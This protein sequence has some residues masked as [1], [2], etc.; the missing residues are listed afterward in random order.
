[1]GVSTNDYDLY[2]LDAT[3]ANV[4]SSS[5]TVQNGSQDPFEIVPPPNV[6]ERVVVVKASG[7]PRFLHI[8]TIRG[9][10]AIGTDGNITGHPCAVNAFATAAVDVHT[11]YPNPFTGGAANPVEYFSTDGPRRVFYNADGTAITPG[12]FSSTG[13]FV[14]Q[15]PDIA[16]ADGVST[17]LP[18][19]SGLNPFYGT[20]AAA[21]HAGAIAALLKSYNPNLTTRQIRGVLTGTALDIEAPGFDFNSGSGIVM[22]LQAIQGAPLPLPVPDLVLTTNYIFGGNGNGV[23]D[24]NECNN[25]IL[26]LDNLG[27]GDATGVRATLSTVTPNVTVAQPSSLYPNIPIGASATNLTPFQVSTAPSFICG[28]PIDFVLVVKSDQNTTTNSFTI[29]GTPG[30][31]LRLDNSVPAFIPDVGITNSIIVVSNVISAISK[32]TVSLYI[33][34]TYDSDLLLQLVSPDGTTNTLSANHGASGHNYGLA[35]SPDS[36]RTTFDDAALIPVSLGAP[37]F[38]GSFIP[39]QPLS[40]FAGKSGTNVNGAWTLLVA[41]QV[42]QDFGTLNCWSLMITPAACADGGGECPGADMAIGMIAQPEPVLLGNNLTYTLSVTNNGPSTA[43]TVS[44]AQSLPSTVVFISAS[45]SQGSCSEVG[46]VVSCNLGQMASHGRATITVVVQPTTLGVLS[47]TATVSSEQTDFDPS[48]NSATAISHVNAPTADLALGLSGAPAATVVGGSLTYS[49]AVTNLGPSIATGVTVTNVLPVGVNILSA[50]SSQGSVAISGN[51]VVCSFGTLAL[52]ARATTTI[53]VLPTAVGTFVA[54]STVYGNQPDP[55]A[56]NNSASVSTLVG[57]SADVAVSI[58]DVPDPVV[59]FS[60]LTYRI[61]VTNAGPSPATSVSLNGSLPASVVVTSNYISQGSLSIA[62]TALSANVGSLLNGATATIVLV[63]T[64]TLNGTIQASVSVSATESDP[65]TAN[66]SASASTFVSAPFVLIAPS[67]ASLVAESF[68]PPDGA[69]DIGETVTVSL[70]LINLGNVR[71]TNLVATL[72]ATNGVTPVGVSTISY[73]LLAPSGFEIGRSFSFTANGTNGGTIAP[74]LHLQD[75]GGYSTNVS[76]TF[77]LPALASFANTNSITIPDPAAPNPPYLWESG[78]AKPYPSTINVSGLTGSISKVTA[79]LSNLT[80]TYVQDVNVL[81]VGPG[82]SESLLMSHVGGTLGVDQV[83]LTF[84]DSADFLP[85]DSDIFSDSYHPT[86]NSPSVVFPAAAPAGPYPAA[87]STFIGVNPNGAWSLYVYDDGEGD[88]GQ[89]ANGWSLAFA[90]VTPINQVADLGVSITASPSSVRVSDYLTYTFT[91][92]NAGPGIANGIAFTNVLPATAA[93]VTNYVS[94]GSLSM[95]GT[96]LVA[97]LGALNPGAAATVTVVVQPTAAG[98]LS[99]T[100]SVSTLSTDLYTANNTATLSVPIGFLPADVALNLSASPSS[101]VLGSNFVFTLTVTNV[102]PG[103]A[104]SVMVTNPLPLGAAFVTNAFQAGTNLVCNLG[105]IPAGATAST[106]LV[107]RATSLGTLTNSATV[108]LGNGQLDPN[109]ANNSASATAQVLLPFINIVPAG[110]AITSE[111]FSPPNGIVDPGETVTVQFSLKNLGSIANSSLTATLLPTGGVTLPSGNQNYG[112]LLPNGPSVAQPFSFIASPA[113]GG[114]LIA[115]L[116]LQDSSGWATNV[117]FLLASGNRFANTNPITIPDHGVAS[118]FPSTIS[119]SGLTGIVTKV[120]V[121]LSNFTHAFPS[122]VNVLLVTTNFNVLLMSHAGGA[123][124]L[125]NPTTITFD[126]NS[127]NPALPVAA[128]ITNGTYRPS[129]YGLT[130]AFRSP[131]APKAPFGSALAAAIGTNPNGEWDLYVLDDSVGDAGAIAG[132]WSLNITTI[133]NINPLADLAVGISPAATALFPRSSAPY[134]ITVTNLGPDSA[135]GVVLTDPFPAGFTVGSA[136]TTQ[137]TV[138]VISSTVIGNLGTL[139]A[140]G[141]ANVTVYATP[142]LDGTFVNTA[143]VSGTV[144]D[145]NPANNSASTS[146]LVYKEP[147]LGSFAAN[148]KFVLAIAATPGTTHTVQTSTN[149]HDWYNLS[150]MTVDFSGVIRF[151]NAPDANAR[152]YRTRH[153]GS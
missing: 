22:A 103:S 123:F 80:H 6:G 89:I 116:Q 148:G 82:G 16:A 117:T 21:P 70:R 147:Q 69:I 46:G 119:V 29:Y 124:A 129:A 61:V 108:S 135:S 101:V 149:L 88:V 4:V 79:T 131:P 145:L 78:P 142:S 5:T 132:G 38:P 143:T 102:G 30:S 81:L 49:L 100:A 130:P 128:L 26:V 7:D 144:T 57:P 121:T 151:T 114:T 134:T 25:L 138:S 37:P 18:A 52:G 51:T 76:F 112:S 42:P 85:L 13:G 146:T 11:A 20:S 136:N 87:L 92:T 23:I 41:D 64:P 58:V 83:S 8:D 39:D 54:T 77:A 113:N 107:F 10:L 48:N 72:L 110:V 104:F 106:A 150:T 59:R 43:K 153:T 94:Q 74:T 68:S 17:T 15:K 40:I 95:S 91:V 120:T 99:N 71:T 73:G 75:V 127:N 34:H 137:G 97:N 67:G 50:T 35:C 90:T 33:T 84:D 125:T 122:D 1:M 24:F 27:R 109:S 118:P 111:S 93:L 62:G 28:T 141:T 36:L 126:D 2:V 14:R 133:N 55:V 152:F 44:V 65:N 140:G 31:P 115:T 63:V 66:N 60:P 96:T 9:Q 98:A 3:G 19:F 56:A 105:T 47:S 12:N 53:S 32:V 45:S 139:P 86:T